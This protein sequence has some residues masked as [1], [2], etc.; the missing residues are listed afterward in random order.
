MR[1][2]RMAT[3]TADRMEQTTAPWREARSL[4]ARRAQRRVLQWDAELGLALVHVWAQRWSG[5]M[6]LAR[7]W[8]ARMWSVR[9]TTFAREGHRSA[10]HR[11]HRP[12]S[13]NRSPPLH[14]RHR[15]ELGTDATLVQLMDSVLAILAEPSKRSSQ[16]Y[17]F[18][19]RLSH[20]SIPAT[21][22]IGS[23]TEPQFAGHRCSAGSGTSLDRRWTAGSSELGSE[24]VLACS[25]DCM[26]VPWSVLVSVPQ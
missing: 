1:C 23:G 12:R 21:T 5:W 4:G 14:V 18:V 16:Q 13:Q 24:S 17:L 6:M 2:E 15:T 8:L 7:T 9:S 10:R 11:R 3:G 22:R 26:W 19:S 20:Q 25:L